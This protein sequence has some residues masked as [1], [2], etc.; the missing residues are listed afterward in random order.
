M[1]K[2]EV[3]GSK[4]FAQGTAHRDHVAELELNI[5]GLHPEDRS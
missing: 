3:R 4:S 5:N 1:N 2:Q